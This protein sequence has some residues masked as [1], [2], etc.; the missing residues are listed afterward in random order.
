MTQNRGIELALVAAI[1][2]FWGLNW[3]AVKFILGEIPPWTFRGFAFFVGAVA[4]GALAYARGE[5]LVPEREEFW[6]LVVAGLLTIFGFNVQ[7]ALGQLLTETARATIIAFTMPLW[8][9]L[10]SVLF[11]GERL[12]AIRM[13][14]LGVGMLG[15]VVLVS[16]GFAAF[17]EAPLGGIFMLGAA[18]SWA[19]GTVALKARDWS[20]P[21]ISRAAWLVGVSAVPTVLVALVIEQPLSFSGV[22]APVAAVLIY[23]IV[24]PMI[25]CYAA[26]VSLVGRM[27]ASSAAIGTLLIPIV[28]VLSAGYFLGDAMTWQKLTALALVLFSI[29][30]TFV[31]GNRTS[32]VK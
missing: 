29:I 17:V 7:T 11:L 19:A 3:P 23:H 20:M 9:A 13:V 14:S 1:G 12:T 26:W 4:L 28:G 24:F 18:I 2:V 22:S 8:A 21:P 30:L 25:V 5:K 27:S 16:E 32:A 10:F 15:L 6:P 31:E